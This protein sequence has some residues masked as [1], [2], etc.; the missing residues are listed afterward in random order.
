MK[1]ADKSK[2]V[3]EGR[4]EEILDAAFAKFFGQLVA[5]MDLDRRFEAKADKKLVQDFITSVDG[6]AKRVDDDDIERAAVTNQ[7]NRHDRW[8]GEL[9]AHTGTQLSAP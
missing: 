9:S 1:K 2:V 8:I 3:T 7:V 4:L 5:Y 6:L